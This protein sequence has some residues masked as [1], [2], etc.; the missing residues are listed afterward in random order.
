MTTSI[1]QQIVTQLDTLFKT[2]LTTGGYNLN[3]GSHVF[4]WRV[5]PL[6]IAELPA[7]V[8]K[9]T[10]DQTTRATGRQDQHALTIEA[11]I[12]INSSDFG[13]TARLAIADF[14]K[15]LGTNVAPNT[16]LG[17]YASDIAPPDSETFEAEHEGIK[18]FGIAI[19]FQVLYGTLRFDPYTAL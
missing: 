18:G 17:G 9:D 4:W 6:Q 10:Q 16:C 11:V 7:I 15:A 14:I 5:T 13:A 12:S 19:T 2:I 3:L 1:R 8:L